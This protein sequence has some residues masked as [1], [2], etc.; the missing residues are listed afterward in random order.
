MAFHVDSR[1][2]VVVIGGGPSGIMAAI[3]A[4]RN[5]ADVLL[6][7]R[8]GYLGGN[9]VIGLAL[10]TFHTRLGEEVVGGLPKEMISRLIGI[11]GSPGP[12]KIRDAHMH[13]TTPVDHELLKYLLLER[14]QEAGVS[15]LLHSTMTDVA[16]EGE[17]V[18]GVVIV[19]KSGRQL[20]LADQFVDA[21]GDGDV[22]M[23]AGA[24]YQ[25]GRPSDG[26]MQACTVLF[27]VARVDLHRV[28]EACGT[29]WATGR[30]PGTNLPVVMWFSAKLTPWNALLE[31]APPP[32]HPDYAF[33]GNSVRSGEAN[34]NATRLT[35]VDGTDARS[36]TRA[37][38]EGRR[39]VM[40]LARFLTA[41]VPGF[42]DAYVTSTAPFVGIRETRRIMGEYVFT[43]ED[44]LSGQKFDDLVVR[45]AY[46]MDI[47]DAQG[48]GTTFR[49]VAS[50]D[51]A[52]DVPYR[53][54]VPLKVENLLIVGRAISA[55]HEAQ[56][57]LRVMVTAMGIGQAAGTASA[58]CCQRRISPRHLEVGL[59]QRRLV[60]QGANLGGRVA[61]LASMP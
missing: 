50:D 13:S 49:Q 37:E 19:N 3:A 40:T 15:I 41:H 26:L 38:L 29:G 31:D 2:D 47:H 17:T 45:A 43:A 53:C 18:T 35:M 4:A 42:E 20:L 33:W 14:V 5:G 16:M 44:I 12:V 9:A 60:E 32:L 61:T 34:I 24:P 59:L 1:H 7:E 21:T 30:E 25:K 55:T 57:A 8:F 46:P 58:L 39:Q 6:V 28:V 54:L 48:K 56:A 36:L 10:H 52:Y 22:A 23:L 27:K 11:G 51:G